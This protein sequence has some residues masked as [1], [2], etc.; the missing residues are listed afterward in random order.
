MN[1]PIN[2]VLSLLAMI[3]GQKPWNVADVLDDVAGLAKFAAAQIRAGN[4]T[5]NLTAGDQSIEV[6]LQDLVDA[7]NLSSAG[8][9]AP[10]SLPFDWKALLR[11]AVE[12]ALTKLLGGL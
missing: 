12:F 10:I 7:A 4:P 2:E 9:A 1:F 8:H 3:R 11:K 6:M 5:A